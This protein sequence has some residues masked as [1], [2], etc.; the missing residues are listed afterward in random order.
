MVVAP[1]TGVFFNYFFLAEQIPIGSEVQIFN[2]FLP[3][4][5]I[6]QMFKSGT[7]LPPCI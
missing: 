1:S 2:L 7:L 5:F 4:I 3:V 6:L